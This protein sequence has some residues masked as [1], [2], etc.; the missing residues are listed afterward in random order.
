M[1][2]LVSCGVI[3]L[4]GLGLILLVRFGGSVLPEFILGPSTVFL[5]ILL[6]L[7]AFATSQYGFDE[8]NKK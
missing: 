7:T 2:Y 8:A 3:V 1:G 4:E 5:I 6:S